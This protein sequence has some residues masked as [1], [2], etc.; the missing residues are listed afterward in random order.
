MEES[1]L[2]G[3]SL[4]PSPETGSRKEG[5]DADQFADGRGENTGS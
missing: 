4:A 5:K 2:E 3:R 1:A